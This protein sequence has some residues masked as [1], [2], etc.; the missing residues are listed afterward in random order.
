MIES[1]PIESAFQSTIYQTFLPVRTATYKDVDADVV[2]ELNPV[3]NI[4]KVDMMLMLLVA[5]TTL[6]L[7][8]VILLFYLIMTK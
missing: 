1:T 7:V 8:A 6:S 2:D 5:N 4:D 3:V